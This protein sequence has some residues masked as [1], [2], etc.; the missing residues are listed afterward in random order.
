MD[1]R[2][3]P[4]TGQLDTVDQLH[5]Q[6]LR[7]RSCFLQAFQRVVVGERE[8][9]HAALMGAGDQGCGGQDTVGGRTVAMQ[10]YLHGLCFR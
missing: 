4:G 8:Q 9:A 10:V 2:A 7:R 6:R 5:V 1:G 3:A